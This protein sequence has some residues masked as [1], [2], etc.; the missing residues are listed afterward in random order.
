MK[1]EV[2]NSLFLKKDIIMKYQ[3]LI[4]TSPKRERPDCTLT[5][6]YNI[7]QL[8]NFSEY[9][10]KAFSS[11]KDVIDFKIETFDTDNLTDELEKEAIVDSLSKDDAIEIQMMCEKRFNL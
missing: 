3:K 5:A 9:L 10:R 2:L 1:K 8:Q 6:S 7:E 11:S 4:A